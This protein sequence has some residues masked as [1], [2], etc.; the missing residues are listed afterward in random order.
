MLDFQ[1]TGRATG[2]LNAALNDVYG[3]TIVARG[4]RFVKGP[5]L[6]LPACSITSV[7]LD[8]QYRQQ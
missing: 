2:L 7:G 5:V 6:T 4:Q 3:T 1:H 8:S